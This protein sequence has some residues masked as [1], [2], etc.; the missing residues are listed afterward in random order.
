WTVASGESLDLLLEVDRVY[1]A[2]EGTARL[3]FVCNDPL[4]RPYYLRVKRAEP[5]DY[6]GWLV[7]DLGTTNTCAALVDETRRVEMV[8][9]DAEANLV[10]DQPLELDLRP[11]RIPETMPSVLCYLTLSSSRRF[12]AGSWAWEQAGHTA[13]ARAVVTGAKR[14]VGDPDFTFEVVPVDEPAETVRVTPAQAMRD[15]YLHTVERAMEH[16]ASQGRSD[17][18]LRRSVITHP[19]RFSVHQI[20]EL[21]D[22]VHG[23]LEAHLDRL[24]PGRGGAEEP[25]TLHEPVGAALHFLNDWRSHA[26]LHV[27]DQRAYHLLVYDYGGGTL[28]ITL[29]KVESQRKLRPGRTAEPLPAR[30]TKRL[31][32]HCRS[33]AA[34]ETGL[35]V[36]EPDELASGNNFLLSQ[37][38]DS[39]VR[40]A[41]ERFDPASLADDPQVNE[42]VLLTYRVNGAQ[43]ERLF[44]RRELLAGLNGGDEEGHPYSYVVT[45]TVLGA[46][47]MRWMGG[48][49]V[50]QVVKELLV[51]RLIKA[52][53]LSEK[54][55]SVELPLEGDTMGARANRN[56]LRVWAENLKVLLSQGAPE[57]ALRDSFRNVYFRLDGEERLISG[58]ALWRQ[59]G[60]PD[61]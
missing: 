60:S 9:L 19:S 58:S 53:R 52:V 14:R 22:A 42:K 34:S 48:E 24:A 59:A 38:V 41:G 1:P 3:H 15:L 4:S 7:I 31:L 56:T 55:G 54:A 49:D 16:L 2:D 11:G 50:T 32:E 61:L 30:L 25:A 47:G 6:P 10:S 20:G 5:R 8:G 40:A 18:L 37:F 26:P 28:D 44:G 36:E 13:A 29:L 27:G 12:R 46:T 33:V 23:A 35:A 39:L 43:Q 17:L 57:D 45:P 51:E 21:K